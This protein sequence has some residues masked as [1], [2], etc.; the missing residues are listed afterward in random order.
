MQ[1]R[2]YHPAFL[3]LIWMC[4]FSDGLAQ[5]HDYI[6]EHIGVRDGLSKNEVTSIVKDHEGF[7]W[8]GTRGG[9]NRYDGYDFDKFQPE[10]EARNTIKNPSIERLYEDSRGNLWIGTKSGGLSRMNL[11]TRSIKHFPYTNDST[12]IHDNR[13]ISFMEDQQGSIWIGKYSSGVS[14]YDYQ[15]GHFTHYD[16][17]MP[18]LGIR[19]LYQ[20]RDGAVWAVGEEG[21]WK[22]NENEDRFH[23]VEL[24]GM[25][26]G[27]Y[28]TSI[29]EDP[30]QPWLWMGG[31]TAG[32]WR[33]N[34]RTGET[35]VYFTS[36]SENRKLS[37][38]FTLAFD[39]QGTMWIG[40]WGM[41][42]WTFD[43][44]KGVL[45]EL[46]INKK[47]HDAVIEEN[48]ILE[49]Y[50]DQHNNIWIGTNRCG[51]VKISSKQPFQN[52]EITGS[53]D[54]LPQKI[55]QI[56]RMYKDDQ[57]NL[58]VGT[59]KGLFWSPPGR[60]A[61]EKVQGLWSSQV[62]SENE[63]IHNIMPL[64]NGKIWI[65][66]T[67]PLAELVWQDGTPAMK[68]CSEIYDNP[69]LNIL[70]P[71]SFIETEDKIYIGT[72]QQSLFV[73]QKTGAG[74]ELERNHQAKPYEAGTVPNERI[75]AMLKD[76][77][78]RKWVGTYMGVGL[79][80]DS[81]FQPIGKYLENKQGLLCQIIN[82]IH[83]D[84][85]GNIWIATPCGLNKLTEQAG[86]QF[87]LTYYTV[88]DG[89][90]ENYINGILEDDQ[91]NIWL[92]T[93]IS[94]T[95]MDVDQ[96]RFVS[97]YQEDGFNVYNFIE[98]S[99]FKDDQGYFYYGG[100]GGLTRFN[101]DS[102]HANLEVPDI[103]FTSLRIWNQPV[104]VNDRFNNRV[105]LNKTINHTDHIQLS[106][107]ENEFSL[108]IAAMD[109]N[110][111][112]KNNY[113]YKLEGHNEEWVTLDNRRR[114][115]FNNLKAGEYLLHVKG[116]NNNNIWS[117]NDRVIRIEITPPWWKTWYAI[118]LY[119]GIVLALVFFI[120]WIAIRQTHLANQV[121]MFKL[122]H[123]HQVQIDEMKFRFFTN[124]SHEFRTP[125]T[126]I[127]GPLDELLCN[128]GARE[129]SDAVRHK[130]ALVRKNALR[131]KKLVNQLIDF[132]KAETGNLKLQV[133]S[134]DVVD[135]M[136]E[137]SLS[138]RE[139]ARINN[140]T[141]TFNNNLS[142]RQVYIDRNK[143]EIVVNNLFSNSIKHVKEGGEVSIHLTENQQYIQIHVVDDGPGIP[144]HELDQIFERFYQI[145]TQQNYGS[146]GIGL[147]LAKRL[148]DLHQGKIDI[149]SQ[150]DH[151]TEFIVSLPKG[152]EHLDASQIIQKSQ[153]KQDRP[154]EFM[155]IPHF[156][157]LRKSKSLKQ[158]GQT[159]LVV[160][161]DHEV[162]E[163]IQELL[164]P[165]YDVILAENGKEALDKA[166]DQKPDLVISDIMM[167]QMDGFEF[168]SKLKK[169]E[170]I[171]D[172]PVI[173][174]TAKSASK[175]EIYGV[176][177]GA[178]DYISKPFD[179][180][181]L[182]EKIN[183]L[184]INR[185]ELQDA[186][187]Q[188]VKVEGTEVEITSTEHQMIQKAIQIIEEHLTDPELTPAFL[189]EKL[190]LSRSTL[191]RKIK[192]ATG[193]PI[194][195]FINKIK[196]QR[197]ASLLADKDK[198][199]TEVA[200]EVGFNSAKH[201]RNCFTR[202]YHQ[203]PGEYQKALAS[204]EPGNGEFNQD[205]ERDD[206][207]SS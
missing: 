205:Q 138:F 119:T 108:E 161:D 152:K 19:N 44:E 180:E 101:P 88:D 189:S 147:A 162:M 93:N 24:P 188:K 84:H 135:F 10:P 139:L 65:G 55:D 22:Y 95:K 5:N 28:L 31:W 69:D 142:N 150:Q 194:I 145:E 47:F 159:I 30:H 193:L 158:N 111:P 120:R 3:F 48:A 26:D 29:M 37:N 146:S 182:K 151:K 15:T 167:P 52:L 104:R 144:P 128:Q 127:V 179:P 71:E 103:A 2:K 62:D 185:K 154:R 181:L 63:V 43:R 34:Y 60:E 81:T 155:D 16:H 80:K 136:E 106:H 163:Y 94:I 148:V 54:K 134:T 85:L 92:T 53:S 83:E 35:Q 118:V 72:Q 192:R 78:G 59:I 21:L 49:I 82:D 115:S 149:S 42:L 74:Y 203:T 33:Y 164:E 172:I 123:Q 57:G 18:G 4:F 66:S 177:A 98:S 143:M 1:N 175:F 204:G 73:Y 165:L 39:Q 109:F 90:P 70:K 176:R 132:R 174:L 196:L 14:R 13:I 137:I 58:W 64:Q 56:T 198:T 202:E 169:N 126:L 201:F 153:V 20:S 130:L 121:E 141:F 168:C 125:L 68:P 122:K 100:I 11:E 50:P 133:S 113:A 75:S 105:I 187:S 12:G 102:V 206:S 25:E 99:S 36:Q 112:D 131:L 77:K 110:N 173:L 184:L 87:K 96:E 91:H 183:N 207:N 7:F 32:L 156:K 200:Y 41:G 171:R 107:R 51:I 157:P 97:F 27:V 38:I 86:G 40:T 46:N 178:D 79:L 8:F 6:I 129:M 166:M 160:E 76:S 114:I 17:Q 195:G 23:L 186:Y 191:Y 45:K 89:L 117:D 197:A 124:I 116:S 170:T 67:N 61:F 9:L 140:I 199:I 190:N